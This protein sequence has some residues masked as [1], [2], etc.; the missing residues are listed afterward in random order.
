MINYQVVKKK[1]CLPL[2][3]TLPSLPTLIT[4]FLE[5]SNNHQS[6]K[7][8]YSIQVEETRPTRCTRSTR[9]TRF[10]RSTRFT[11]T[12]INNPRQITRTL[13]QIDKPSPVR[14]SPVIS[15]YPWQASIFYRGTL[16]ISTVGSSGNFAW[17]KRAEGSPFSKGREFSASEGNARCEVINALGRVIGKKDSLRSRF[18][19]AASLLAFLGIVTARPISSSVFRS[20]RGDAIIGSWDPPDVS[21]HDRVIAPRLRSLLRR[22]PDVWW[23]SWASLTAGL[24]MSRVPCDSTRFDRRGIL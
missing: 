11:R 14:A 21:V 12:E 16:L 10:T 24:R 1:C 19:R 4:S 7:T 15:F 20:G 13:V 5:T 22:Q 6:M 3:I 9:F 18:R 8:N 17:R 2:P 23:I